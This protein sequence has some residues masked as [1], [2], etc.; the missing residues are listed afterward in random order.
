MVGRQ[1]DGLSPR[2]MDA[3]GADP[4]ITRDQPDGHLSTIFIDVWWPGLISYR[5]I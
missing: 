1:F 4:Y 5:L 3:T 2:G